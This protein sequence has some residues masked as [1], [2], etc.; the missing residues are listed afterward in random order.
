MKNLTAS[1]FVLICSFANQF[2][3]V[4]LRKTTKSDCSFQYM[5]LQPPS[6]VQLCTL[7][8]IF[9]VLHVSA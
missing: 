4:I 1:Y 6:Q 8:L 2:N 5:L 3:A 7:E 9:T